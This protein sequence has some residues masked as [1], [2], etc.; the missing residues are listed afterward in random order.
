MRAIRTPDQRLRVF[1]SSTLGE[2]L[3][4]LAVLRRGAPSEGETARALQ[5]LYDRFT[6]GIDSPHLVAARA[7]L[8]RYTGAVDRAVADTVSDDW[9]VL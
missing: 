5:E 7:A 1:I 9:D 4:H 6:E 8:A 2:A 3:T